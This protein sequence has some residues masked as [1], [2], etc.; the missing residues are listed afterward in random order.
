M[1]DE[2]DSGPPARPPQRTSAR[3]S[4]FAALDLLNDRN[5]A[6]EN[7]DK[8]AAELAGQPDDAS[9]TQAKHAYEQRKAI[10]QYKDGLEQGAE[11]CAELEKAYSAQVK[12]SQVPPPPETLGP[13]EA[14]LDLLRGRNNADLGDLSQAAAARHVALKSALTHERETA[15]RLLATGQGSAQAIIDILRPVS[16]LLEIM[17]MPHTPR[18]LA[19]RELTQIASFPPEWNG[20]DDDQYFTIGQMVLWAMTGDR[21]AVDQASNDSGRR[22]EFFGQDRAK[23]VFDAL[24][25]SRERIQH[26]AD[27]LWRQCLS[28]DV[29][30][31]DYQGRPIPKTDWLQLDVLLT[32]ENT[33]WIARRGQSSPPPGGVKVLFPRAEA[34]KL[35]KFP[36]EGRS[37]D[38]NVAAPV[39]GAEG[40]DLTSQGVAE[41]EQSRTPP[42]DNKK[43]ARLIA[44]IERQL[45][46]PDLRGRTHYRVTEIVDD[47]VP[48]NNPQ[49]RA[50]YFRAFELALKD[51]LFNDGERQRSRLFCMD[52]ASR[53][54]MRLT[55][56]RLAMYLGEPSAKDPDTK[57]ANA[58]AARDAVV[59]VVWKLDPAIYRA[60]RLES[61]AQHTWM[62]R[63][64][65]GRWLANYHLGRPPSWLEDGTPSG[66]EQ[67]PTVL[68]SAPAP[69]DA[70]TRPAIRASEPPPN[71]A[72]KKAVTRKKIVG[73]DTYANHQRDTREKLGRWATRAEDS[74]LAK[75]NGF[76]RDS[77]R[78][79]RRKFAE[80]LSRADRKEF[81]RSGPRN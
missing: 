16:S 24:N 15:L 17:P 48:D 62:P 65:V 23:I 58:I 33:L 35:R 54:F 70:P 72:I 74:E 57:D 2:N 3:G 43:R 11:I 76:S 66:A 1:T 31:C 68:I 13:F 14:V 34:E 22:G 18:I 30:A 80:T 71:T 81:E 6:L 59:G 52:T 55:K 60:R 27:K 61:L 69:L 64:F 28:G 26:A 39:P 56:D 9:Y 79:A 41:A 53:R 37:E 73:D 49:R 10:D 20:F 36:P 47:R 44:Q 42:L 29:K 51:G 8:A 77:V 78:T 46:A 45:T 12:E 38:H 25:L 50:E 7:F 4:Y 67:T 63:R 19:I 75:K 21:W 40:M 5:S 32:M